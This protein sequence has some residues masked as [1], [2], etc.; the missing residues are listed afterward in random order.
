[1]AGRSRIK[2]PRVPEEMRQWSELLLQEVLDWPQVRSRPMFGMIAIY[3]GNQIFG[4]LPRTRAMETKYSISFKLPRRTPALNRA[5]AHDGRI[6]PSKK[7]GAKW[8]SFEMRSGDDFRDA[9]EWLAR[10]YRAA[11]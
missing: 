9:V 7:P 6:V 10:A 5:L 8:I 4:A 11:K 2:L 3:R 1:M